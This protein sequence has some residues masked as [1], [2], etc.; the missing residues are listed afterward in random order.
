M[1][2]FI[3][4]ALAAIMILSLGSCSL[5]TA[6]N[7]TTGETT[8]VG[9]IGGADGPTEVI[10][11]T[12]VNTDKDEQSGDDVSSGE[13]DSGEVVEVQNPQVTITMENGDVMKAE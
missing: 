10:V 6:T 2:R 11:S 1:K 3:S 13:T 8:S 12:P 7:L 4:I 9:I 5:F